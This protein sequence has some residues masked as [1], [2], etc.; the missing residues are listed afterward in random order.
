MTAVLM[1]S[2]MLPLLTF[3]VDTSVMLGD[4]NSD[5]KINSIDLALVQKHILGTGVL[6]DKAL[7][8]ADVDANGNVDTIDLALINKYLM[9]KITKFPGEEQESTDG[10]GITWMDGKTLFPLGVNYAWYSWTYD[11]SDNNWSAN[12]NN[13]KSDMDTM[14]K[15]G[16]HALRWWV[17]P[18][19]AWGPTWSGKD[20]GSLCTGLP[21]NWVKN[22]KAACDYA[23]SK[24]IKI[25]WTI[26]SFD[27]SRPD[28]EVDHD[29]VIDNAKVRQSFFD[30]ALKPI[31]LELGDH[32]GVMGWD[33]I[34]EP[35]WIVKSEDGGAAR[36][37]GYEIF[38]LKSMREF[39]KTT[40]A[41]IHQYAKQPVSFGSANMKWLGAQYDLWDDLDV[42][43][44]DF[45]WY[46]WA[47]EWFN[48]IKTPA[49]ALNLDKPVIIGEMMPNTEDSSLKM[50]HKE[51]LDA[52][53]ANG[54]A[55]YLL[56]SWKD[57]SFDCKPY[58]KN[59]FID[60]GVEHPE[61]VR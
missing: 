37:D 30:N 17:F 12:F 43:F 6:E 50:S 46:D 4:V 7:T 29:D 58:I 36:T 27:V 9:G 34:N 35:E 57:S 24:D 3:A 23:L 60:F 38:S 55:G 45:H 56:W 21:N 22:M 20:E 2:M 14:A 32:K 16:I 5:G 31:L 8:A 13:I 54:Y 59:N 47:T 28:D 49:S 18:D 25:Y 41:Y 11:F 51:V 42:D 53:Y 48:P 33:V 52:I 39:I 40:V 44:Y 19:L 15:K 1:I 26:T 61:E 10:V